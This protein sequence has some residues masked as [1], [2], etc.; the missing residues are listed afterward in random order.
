[1]GQRLPEGYIYQHTLFERQTFNKC[2]P[3]KRWR[4]NPAMILPMPMEDEQAL[5]RY[6]E[7]LPLPSNALAQ[8]ALKHLYALPPIYGR[9][10]RF[11]GVQGLMRQIAR[12]HRRDSR[13]REA[14][15]FA[16][17]FEAQRDFYS[18][19]LTADEE[20]QLGVFRNY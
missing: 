4:Q 11:I 15:I 8:C 3:S 6:L 19:V 13:G 9:M 1:M 20:R 5:H 7:G 16:E 17:H 18:N 12:T 10:E 14:R 2:L